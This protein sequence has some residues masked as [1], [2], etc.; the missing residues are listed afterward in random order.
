MAKNTKGIS[1]NERLKSM[2]KGIFAIETTVNN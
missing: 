2:E 1:I